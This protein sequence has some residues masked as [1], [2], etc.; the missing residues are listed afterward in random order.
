MF[1]ERGLKWPWDEEEQKQDPDPEHQSI[2]EGVAEM[3]ED[4]EQ[5]KEEGKPPPYQPPPTTTRIDVRSVLRQKREATL[6]HRTQFSQDGL[7]MTLPD[8]IAEVALGEEHYS[9][10]KSH[11]QAPEQ[12]DDLLAGLD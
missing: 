12:E 8:D 6:V 3:Q 11:V 9:L 10:I 7:F 2:E 1:I 4:I 5:A